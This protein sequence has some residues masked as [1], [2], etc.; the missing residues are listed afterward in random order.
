[1]EIFTTK[2]VAKKLKVE[3]STIYRL[4]A[5]GKLGYHKVGEVYRYTQENIDNYLKSTATP[6]NAS[7]R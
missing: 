7:E 4:R 2:E 5:A 1:M 6:P 3:V